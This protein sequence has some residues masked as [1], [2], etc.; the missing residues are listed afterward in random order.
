MLSCDPIQ[1][2]EIRLL[3]G[4][5]ALRAFADI[6]VGN[7]TIH[8]FRVIKQN[9]QKAFVSP[10]QTS[11][12]DPRTGEI[13]YRGILTLPPELKQKIEI[14]VLSAFQEELEKKHGKTLHPPSI[15]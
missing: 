6:Q 1:V 11:W 2:L 5:K 4:N 10:P 3:N 13:R 15:I 8:D 14:A 7:W 9:G 12:K